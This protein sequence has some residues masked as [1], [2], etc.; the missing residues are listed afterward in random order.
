MTPH[1]QARMVKWGRP[2]MRR[3]V[4]VPQ[5]LWAAAITTLAGAQPISSVYASLTGLPE[6]TSDAW[7][8]RCHVA[9]T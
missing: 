9:H 8:G 4:T 1:G 5:G 7:Y 6:L 2:T 3:C